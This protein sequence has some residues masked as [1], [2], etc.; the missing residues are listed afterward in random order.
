MIGPLITEKAKSFYE[1]IQIT[2]KRTFS[3]NWTQNFT[4][5]SSWGRYPHGIFNPLISCAARVQEH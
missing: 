3:K 1:E 2:D 5:T 4:I